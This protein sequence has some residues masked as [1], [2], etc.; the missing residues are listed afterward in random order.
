MQ[1]ATGMAKAE[2]Q[3]DPLSVSHNLPPFPAVALKALNII[4]GTEVSLRQ[5]CDVIRVDAA[6]SAEILKIANS[7][8]IAF[9]TPVISVLQASMLLGFRRLRNVAITVGLRSYLNGYSSPALLACWR[10]SLAC[11]MVAERIAK[12]SYVDRD[13]A[14]TAGVMHD[15]GRVALATLLPQSYVRVVELAGTQPQDV[16]RIERDLCGIDHCAAGFALVTAWKLPEQFADITLH[17]HDPFPSDTNA[18]PVLQRSCRIADALG[19]A[20]VPHGS[21]CTYQEILSE[22]SN[23]V[24]KALPEDPNVLTAEIQGQISVIESA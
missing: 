12:P 24:R 2:S 22:C 3:L 4:A 14:Y 16:L 11:A 18:I 13:F 9:S 8:L 17:H 19:F 1:T 6:F 23:D 10:H 15:I 7:P 21:L 20:A 5:L